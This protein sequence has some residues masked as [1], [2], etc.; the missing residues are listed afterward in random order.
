MLNW[1]KDS[2]NNIPV[3]IT[4]NGYPDDTGTLDDNERA[5]ILVQYIDEVLKGTL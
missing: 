3:Y 1:I 4:E 5:S 2:Y